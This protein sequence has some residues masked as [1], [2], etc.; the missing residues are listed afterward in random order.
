MNSYISHP[1]VT[2]SLPISLCSCGNFKEDSLSTHDSFRLWRN[3]VKFFHVQ[4]AVTAVSP[5]RNSR[6]FGHYNDFTFFFSDA[7]P[8]SVANSLYVLN[9]VIVIKMTSLM[10]RWLKYLRKDYKPCLHFAKPIKC[11]CIFVSNNKLYIYTIWTYVIEFPM[12][13]LA[14]LYSDSLI[15]TFI[16]ENLEPILVENIVII[17][18]S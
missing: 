1:F 3:P 14:F 9:K 17:I 15:C 8:S 2:I 16:E 6:L 10:A 5:K 12:W 11:R 13:L 18:C 7:N 4:T